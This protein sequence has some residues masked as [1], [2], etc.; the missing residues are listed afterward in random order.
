MTFVETELLEQFHTYD[1]SADVVSVFEYLFTEVAGLAG[2]VEHFER[3]P[4]VQHDDGNPATP[5]FAVVFDDHSGLAGEIANFALPEQ[6]VDDLCRQIHRYDDLRVLPGS[7]GLVDV[8]HVDVLLIVPVRLGTAAIQRIIRDRL[9]DGDHPYAPKA[10]PCVVQWGE[11][12]GLYSF[13]KLG[14][15]ENGGLREGSRE[16]AIGKWL[17]Q[18]AISVPIERFRDIKAT[19]V[20]VNDPTDALY[21]AT[22]LWAKTFATIA[23]DAGVESPAVLTV[24]ASQIA[25]LLRDQF[26]IGRAADVERAMGILAR[27]RLAEQSALGQWSV[28]WNRLALRAGEND[29]HQA[30]AARAERPPQTSSLERARRAEAL[31]ST[32]EPQPRLF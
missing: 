16:P 8:T 27:A 14:E 13:S 31:K 12:G 11:D 3:F 5:D 28:G 9:L 30:L 19:R 18:N 21:L 17:E 26:G 23:G 10:R 6:S 24:A 4:A 2:T 25:Q 20:F 32:A 1:R 15:A 29:L 22:H 7:K